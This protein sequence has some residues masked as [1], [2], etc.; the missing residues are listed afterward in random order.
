RL[1]WGRTFD[2]VY[3]ISSTFLM[4]SRLNW[5]RFVEPLTNFSLGY[6]STS[7]GLPSSLSSNAPRKILPRISFSTF[8]ALGDTGGTDRPLD[9][10]QIFESFT[11]IQSKHSL[12]FG[13]DLRQYR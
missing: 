3:T 7:L 5:T 11:K 13:V 10:F 9:I 2:D 4:H 12:K 1:N 6:D 8:T